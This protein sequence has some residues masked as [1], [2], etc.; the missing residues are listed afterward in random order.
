MIIKHH[1]VIIMNEQIIVRS[2]KDTKEQNESLKT[3]SEVYL[4]KGGVGKDAPEIEYDATLLKEEI[5]EEIK[6]ELK[7]GGDNTSLD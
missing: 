7:D 3:G 2:L 1:K 4:S 6:E 5:K